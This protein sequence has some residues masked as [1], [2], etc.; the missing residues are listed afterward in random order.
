MKALRNAESPNRIVDMG[1]LYRMNEMVNLKA[2]GFAVCR[3]PVLLTTL[4]VGVLTAGPSPT[5]WAQHS[6]W[7][8]TPFTPSG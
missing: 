7:A 2:R 3:H 8:A 1:P 6:G 4:T 5:A